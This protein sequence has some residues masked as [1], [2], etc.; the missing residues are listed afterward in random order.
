MAVIQRIL[1]P[2]DFSAASADAAEQA[3]ALARWC[4]ARITTLHVAVPEPMDVAALSPGGDAET[5]A[6][7]TAIRQKTELWAREA[8]AAGL[9]AGTIVEVGDPAREILDWATRLPADVIVMGTHGAS[10]FEHLML[11]SVTE[12][13]LRNATCPVL[14]VPPRAHARASLPPKRIVCGVDFSDWS[15]AAVDLAGSMAREAGATLT[16]V[17]AIEWPWHEPPPPAFDELPPE[18][19]AALKE[20]RRYLE[21]SAMARL[22]ALALTHEEA[23]CGVRVVHGKSYAEILRVVDQ[24]RADLIVLGVHGRTGLDLALFGSTTNHVVRQARCPVLTLRR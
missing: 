12:R 4:H 7:R 16:L 2:T 9:N 11:G 18:Q 17:H 1:Y 23:R 15:M 22:R 20:Y 6:V 19:A 24:E 8:E 14:T 5:M 10:G 3:I 21:E 13:V